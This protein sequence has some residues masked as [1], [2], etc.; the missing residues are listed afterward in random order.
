[1]TLRQSMKLAREA[2][3]QSVGETHREFRQSNAWKMVKKALKKKK[4]KTW[5]LP[6]V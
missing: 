4:V 1:M 5:W 6:L 3:R 2:T